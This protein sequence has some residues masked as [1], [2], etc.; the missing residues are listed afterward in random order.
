MWSKQAG[1]KRN[2]YFQKVTYINLKRM[3]LSYVSGIQHLQ[4]TNIILLLVKKIL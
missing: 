4:K 2:I 1:D 3:M